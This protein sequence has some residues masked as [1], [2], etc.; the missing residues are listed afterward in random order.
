MFQC[1]VTF[2]GLDKMWILNSQE[3][4]HGLFEKLPHRVKSQF[5]SVSTDGFKS[6]HDL[7]ILVEKS[8][9]EAESEF[10]RL[11]YKTQHIQSNQMRSRNFAGKPQ[12]VCTAQRSISLPLNK[13]VC[14]CCEGHHKLWQC[15]DFKS[16]SIDDR[17]LIVQKRGLCFNCL[18]P[19][20][21]ISSCRVK[22]ACGSCGK[23]H[24]TLLHWYPREKNL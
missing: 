20:H 10:G 4:L 14:A 5:V 11:L 6:F 3:L 12:R 23:K 24:N 22:I 15:P 19:G 17:R 16:K 8:A 18:L 13:L 7:R 9:S 2:E 1:E 21:Q